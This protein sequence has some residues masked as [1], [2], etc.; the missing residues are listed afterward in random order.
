MIEDGEIK[1]HCENERLSGRKHH[2]KAYDLLDTI[3]DS[4]DYLVI[5]G[6]SPNKKYNQD[7]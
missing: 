7:Y 2:A 1:L 6:F 5:S 3:K 4:I